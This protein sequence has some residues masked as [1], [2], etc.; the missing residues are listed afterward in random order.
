MRM[1]N[2]LMPLL[3]GLGLRSGLGDMTGSGDFTGTNPMRDGKTANS[4][5]RVRQST[6]CGPPWS[7]L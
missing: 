6:R 4:R 2:F 1:P 5:E 3:I 7:R